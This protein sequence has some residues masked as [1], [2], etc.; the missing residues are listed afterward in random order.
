MSNFMRI[1]P[2]GSAAGLQPSDMTD[3]G[4]FTTDDKTELND[5]DE[6]EHSAKILI[7]LEPHDDRVR[8]ETE[9]RGAIRRIVRQQP[10]IKTF[11][12]SKPSVLAFN[13]PVIGS[14]SMF[15]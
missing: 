8:Q 12:F 9:T 2:Q 1:L 10:D 6:G 15:S 13:A 14:G 11:R 3:P 4:A 7:T 5:S